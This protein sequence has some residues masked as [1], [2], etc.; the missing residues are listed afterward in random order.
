MS[1]KLNNNFASQYQLV[2]RC[3]NEMMGLLLKMS[4]VIRK[5]FIIL[6]VSLILITII[7]LYFN[8]MKSGKHV[9]G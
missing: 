6:D 7:L 9:K 4:P 1:E 5:I 8:L 3:E 2:S